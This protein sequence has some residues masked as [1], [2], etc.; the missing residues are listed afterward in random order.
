[1]LMGLVVLSS[2][3]PAT[4]YE[5]QN[6]AGTEREVLHYNV[7]ATTK[8]MLEYTMPEWIAV[9]V[10]YL[11]AAGKKSSLTVDLKYAILDEELDKVM[12]TRGD[13]HQPFDPVTGTILQ[14]I[15]QR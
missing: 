5:T 15:S 11:D 3:R 13:C 4:K 1:M 12:C 2:S 10:D 7:A 8:K 9:E 14:N 6:I